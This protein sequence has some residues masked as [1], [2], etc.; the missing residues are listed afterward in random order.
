MVRELLDVSGRNSWHQIE[1]TAPL[2]QLVG[3]LSRKDIHRVA[4]VRGSHLV[5]VISQSDLLRFIWSHKEHF[6]ET[7]QLR[8]DEAWLGA[9]ETI[10]D[11][12]LVVE[13]FR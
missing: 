11:S 12:E 5:S 1:P 6:A 7:L 8:M 9:V 3:F 10:G 2:S 4:V 13:A